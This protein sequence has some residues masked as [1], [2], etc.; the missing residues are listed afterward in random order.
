MSMSPHIRE[1]VPLSGLTT[2]HLGGPARFLA[3]CTNPDECRTVLAFARD[4]SLPVMVL[5]GGS[6]VIFGDDGYPGLVLRIEIQGLDFTD[7]GQTCLVTAGAGEV[8]DDVV[9]ACVARGLGGIECL[10]GIPGTAGATPIQ[11]V[12]AYGQEVQETIEF[13]NVLERATGEERRFGNAE[14]GFG[15]RWSRF[16]G[17][18]AGR[19]IVTSV[20]FRLTQNALPR[21]HY[22][23]LAR[24]IAQEGSVELLPSG[25]PAL[26]R[27]RKAVL[28]IRRTKAMVIDPDDPDCRSVGSFFTNPV[29][30]PAKFESLRQRWLASYQPDNLPAYPSPGGVKVPAA[31]LVEHAGFPKG[32][33]RG[34]VGIS[35]KHA[36]A[37]VNRG[38]TARE[39]IAFAQE[40]QEGVDQKFGIRLAIEPIIVDEGTHRDKGSDL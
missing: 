25:G 23:E 18:D 6:N 35:E 10:A 28:R 27:V 12:G 1:A 19:Y 38:G 31:W 39:L 11:N 4:R 8:W 34:N 24:T 26:N 15:Y 2:I 13:V 14:C 9:T 40:I 22:P 20:G 37:L 36:L 5:G 3:S 7:S 32:T 33:R 17:E 16:K 29:L 21:I 30:D